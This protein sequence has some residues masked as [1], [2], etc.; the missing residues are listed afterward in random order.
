MRPRNN[1]SGLVSRPAPTPL[2]AAALN[3]AAEDADREAAQ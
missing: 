1:G 2:I 3:V